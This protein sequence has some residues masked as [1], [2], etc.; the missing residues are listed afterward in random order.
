MCWFDS[1][2][3]GGYSGWQTEQDHYSSEVKREYDG[4]NKRDREIE[5]TMDSLKSLGFK[6][7]RF[8]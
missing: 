6:G 3:A 8:K 7:S 1:H 2:G 4:P 5:E